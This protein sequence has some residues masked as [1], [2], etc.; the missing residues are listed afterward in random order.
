MIKVTLKDGSVKEFEKGVS[1]LDVARGISEGLARNALCGIVNG[2]VVDLRH[3]L[4]DDV[5]LSICT[6]DSKEGKDAL[7]HT[8]SHVLA[9]AVKRLFPEVKIAIGPAIDNGFYYDFDKEV[10]FTTEDLQ[11]I[12]AEMKKIIKENPEIER[13]ELPIDEALEL[14]KD[15]PYK[16]ELINDLGEDEVIS[17]YKIGDF[18][19]LCAGPHIMSLKPMKAVKLLRSAGAYW[20]GDENHKMLSRIYG[21]AFLKNKDLEEHLAALEEAKKRDH[22]KLGRELKL[23]TTDENVGQGLPLIMPRGSRI[24][25]TLQRWIEDEEERRG[26]VL[27][28]TPLMAKSDLYKISGHWDHYKDGMF[29]L[30]DEEKD[31]EV[32]A[33][34]PMTCPFQYAIYN[35]EQHSYRD[36]PVRYAE[37]ST[38]FRNESSGEMHGLIRVRQFTLADGH[39]VCTPEQLEEEF[40]GA[41]DLIKHVMATLGIDGDISYRFSKW[42]PNN[43]KKYINDPEAW[44]RTQDIMKKILDHLEIDY[45]EAD[46]EAAFY[47]PKLDIQ[48]KNVHGKEDT[49][50]TVQIDFALAERFNMTYIDKDGEK[51]RPYII[52]RS[53]IGCYE[54]TLAMLI[55]KYAGAFPTWLAPVQAKVLPLS[56]KYNDYAE[57]IVKDLR[58]NGVRVEGDYRAE[59]LGYK[60]REARLERTPYI[61]VVGEKEMANNEVSVRS[62]KN[63]DEGSMNYE[64]FKSRLLLEILNKD[65]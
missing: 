46:D 28:K 25:Q 7:R 54:R 57:K 10:A 64:A 3:T 20:R 63:D 19:D 56:D 39:I 27:T 44:E 61:L 34:R 51:K 40:K 14:M 6:F 9:Y 24:I 29:V 2:E 62:R 11:K 21:T 36:L 50:I 15:E 41:V 26:Y 65:L 53:S 37:T 23:F 58:N 38:L 8:A 1:V 45:V 5:E 49:I 43:T 12:E 4:N 55:E 52:H 16:V 31:D 32:F 60:I 13:F 47:G 59:K 22:N 33:L 42:D 48:F 35:S 18:T 17:F 30:G